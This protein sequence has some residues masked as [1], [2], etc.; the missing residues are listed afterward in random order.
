MKQF[1]P[2]EFQKEAIERLSKV[3]VDVWKKSG[4][5]LPIVL[6]SPTG[7]GKTFIASSFIRGL[8]HLPQWQE[9]KTFIWIT[10]SDDLAIQSKKK[11]AEYFENNL[12]NNLI[13]V[14]DI[15]R[16]KLFSNDIV[17]LNWQKIVSKSAENRVL[18]RPEDEMMRKERGAYWED[19]I[20]GTHND[21]REIILIIDEAHKNKNT[22]LAKEI[23]DY[24]NPKIILHITATPD[25]EDELEAYRMGTMIEVDRQKVVEQGLIKEKIV[26]QTEEDLLNHQGQDLDKALL[27]L[28]IRR[29][30][31]LNK[32]YKMLGK[33]VN[34][35]MLI[36][37][38]NDDNKLIEMAKETKESVVCDYL[39]EI[40]IPDKK[41]AKWFDGRQENMEFIT[42]NDSDT[43]Y[44]LFKQAAGTGWDCPRAS[45]LVMFR[46][47]KSDKFY[48]QT[49]GRIL[50][51]AEPELKEDYKDNECLRIGYLYT[52]YKRNQVELPDGSSSNKPYIHFTNIKEGIHNIELQS[53]Y[54]SR[55]D[56]GDIP[57]SFKFQQSFIESMNN[58][59]G[60]TN[61]DILGKVQKK[62]ENLKVDLD[63]RLTNQIIV[64]AEFEDFDHLNYEFK[65]EGRD[66]E[67]EMSTNDVE[68]TF[69]YICYQLLQ[70]QDNVEAKYTNIA[71]SWSTLKS[72]IRIWLK[73]TIGDDSNYFYRVFVKDINKGASSKFRPAITKA[74]IDFKPISNQILNEKKNSHETKEAPLFKIQDEYSFTE[75]YM[76]EG[77][78]LCALDKF[79]ILKGDY[80]GKRNELNFKNYIDNLDSSII[81]WFKNGDYGKIY[82]AL[83]YT[84]SVD[85]K[86][87]L[88]Y[89][90]WIIY[91]KDGRIGIFDTKDGDTAKSQETKDKASSLSKRLK[92]L[93]S[94]YLGGIVVKSSGIWYFNNS[95]S[96]VYIEGQVEQDE[97]WK[98][99]ESI[100]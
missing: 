57:K 59:F 28:G 21:S 43:D 83:K 36:Q 81:W 73:K 41:I 17:F 27:D 3:F 11:F 31:D 75:D 63:G 1:N 14:E 100:L 78:K 69:N 20:D 40:G 45:V 67:I 82:Y 87:S 19:L 89:P 84:D 52:N 37:L 62:L 54:I 7:S 66:L 6:K 80:K 56:Y 53:E 76:E 23:I 97:N 10:F 74:L 95:T 39:K 13:T 55:V 70:E 91:F 85:L 99:F 9:D 8:N 25:K 90:D 38:P 86:E 24:I 94:K 92:E 58:Y 34:P 5:K 61:N 29:R 60:I 50:R 49:V 88:F 65:R 18:R 35:L 98:K 93:G 12:E 79:Y 68:K 26:V 30:E 51:M 2:L 44:M 33:D 42:E 46:E 32:E 47:I 22:V 64:N 71:R 4:K 15:N 96:Y 77:Q 16:G 72:A 48:T